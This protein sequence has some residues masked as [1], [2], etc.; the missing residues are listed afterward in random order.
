MD[1]LVR[2]TAEYCNSVPEVV[3]GRFHL[4]VRKRLWHRPRLDA[5]SGQPDLLL[6]TVVILFL[7]DNSCPNID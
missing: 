3:Q 1:F 6:N 7:F 2:P 5:R 4:H